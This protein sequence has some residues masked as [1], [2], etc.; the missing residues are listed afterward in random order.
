MK[1]ANIFCDNMVFQAEKPI[2]FFGE[3]CGT[4]EITLKN[5]TYK[6]SFFGDTWKMELPPQPYGSAFE[7]LVR[8]ED[9][10]IVLKNVAFGDVFLCAGQSNMQFSIGEEKGATEAK[11]DENIRYIVSSGIKNNSGLQS[12][13]WKICKEGEVTYWSALA[14]HLAQN[15]R[16]EKDVVVGI[17]GCFQ[18]ASVIRSWLPSRVLDQSV[19]VAMQER[20]AD[21]WH[22]EYG[23]WNGDSF[24]YEKKFLPIV[25]YSMKGIIWYQGESNTTISE[26][27]VYLE[28]L[29]RLI[30]AWRAD[31]NDLE[32]PF[33]VVEICDFDGRN[34]E[35]WKIIQDCQQKIVDY[36]KNVKTVTS[37]DVCESDNIHPANKE[38][39][40]EKLS[41]VLCE[42]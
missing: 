40:A 25:P 20:H 5:H 2:R 34:D 7:I 42:F 12:S 26:G 8:L 1:L 32:L 3:G 11:D 9:E 33:V 18:G 28:L 29:A 10:C 38:K 17:I 6:E 36:C 31:L 14:L 16:K 19:Y 23:L 4:V 22:E 30:S 35:G 41:K 21:N 15:Y 39:L 24:L 13:G 27:R 37:K